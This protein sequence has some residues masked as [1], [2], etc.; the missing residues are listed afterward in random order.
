MSTETR[1][2][3]LGEGELEGNTA[4]DTS[5]ETIRSAGTAQRLIALTFDDGPA[6]YTFD[7]VEIRVSRHARGPT[8]NPPS[9]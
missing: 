4:F 2:S 6:K 7:K 1:Y 5:V 9:L 3:V 8:G